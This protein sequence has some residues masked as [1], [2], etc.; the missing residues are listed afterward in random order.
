MKL[1]ISNLNKLIK[2]M[3][4]RE[5]DFYLYLIKRQNEIGFVEGI[6]HA[7]MQEDIGMPRSTF[8]VVLASLE[9]K[10]MI[11]V[12]WNNRS[13]YFNFFIIDNVFLSLKDYKKAYLNI[14]IDFILSNEFVALSVNMKK[15]FLRL[16]SLKAGKQ[17]V[18]ILNDTLKK[19]KVAKSMTELE[20]LFDIVLDGEGYLFQVKLNL[21]I[22]QS[23]NSKYFEIERKVVTYCKN[24]NIKYTKEELKDTISTIT[25]GINASKMAMIHT[26]LDKCRKLLRLQ[27]KLITY[28]LYCNPY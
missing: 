18:K 6:T 22:K 28:M 2:D 8:H 10:G 4:G 11:R 19:Y 27:P 7:Q 12:D 1:K 16:L 3:S 9:E 5:I 25:N 21:I 24:F 17:Q 26:A 14:N 15:F 20:K 13:R 23:H